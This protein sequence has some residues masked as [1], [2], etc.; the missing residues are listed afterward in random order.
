M[1]KSKKARRLQKEFDYLHDKVEQM[2]KERDQK[3]SRDWTMKALI[4]KHKKLKL[5]VKD[6]LAHLE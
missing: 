6:E 3:G 4:T 5:K 1:N 2:E